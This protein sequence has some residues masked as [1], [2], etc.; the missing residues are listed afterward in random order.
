MPESGPRFER[1]RRLGRLLPSD[2]R[3][4]V[5]EPAFGDLLH[6]WLTRTRRRRTP[7]GLHALGMLV[8][9]A[10][11]AVPRWFVRDGR[12]TRFGR[13]MVWS[14]AAITSVALILQAAMQSY[15]D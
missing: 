8:G 4:R 13:V 5:F 12:L 15:Y 1:W 3:E 2:V 7:F 6:G 10:P 9:C 11:I 14:G